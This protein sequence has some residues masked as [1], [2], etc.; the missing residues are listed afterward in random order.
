M[1]I[2]GDGPG[3]FSSLHTAASNAKSGD[4]I[5]LRFNG[6]RVEK[7][8]TVSNIKLTIVAAESFEPVVVFRPE[9]KDPITYPSSM[10]TVGGVLIG[11][12]SFI[13][14]DVFKFSALAAGAVATLY[15]LWTQGLVVYK[16]PPSKDRPAVR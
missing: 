10:I 12:A 2:V 4:V 16:S 7:P 5:E 8:I 15:G 11:A 3:A 9:P 14:S 1:L 13:T 6:R